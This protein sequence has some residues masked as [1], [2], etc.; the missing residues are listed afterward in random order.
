[1]NCHLLS[2]SGS[3]LHLVAFVPAIDEDRTV[4]LI[5]YA[6][7]SVLTQSLL[8]INNVVVVLYYCC[9]LISKQRTLPFFSSH[10]VRQVV[11]ESAKCK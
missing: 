11:L 5:G 7:I 2:F 10:R 3:C 4:S 9:Y 6:Y 1:L 8:G